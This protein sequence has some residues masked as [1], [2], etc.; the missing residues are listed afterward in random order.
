MPPTGDIAKLFGFIAKETP[1]STHVFNAAIGAGAKGVYNLATGR[2]LTDGMVGAGIMGAAA[3]AGW[4]TYKGMGLAG[5]VAKAE[6]GYTGAMARVANRG[7]RAAAAVEAGGFR[8]EL[9]TY[10][11]QLGLPK[12]GLTSNRAAQ[13]GGVVADAAASAERHVT[14][15][16]SSPGSGPIGQSIKQLRTYDTSLGSSIT[17]GRAAASGGTKQIPLRQYDMAPG[18]KMTQARASQSRAFHYQDASSREASRL[19]GQTSQAQASWT[20][21]NQRVA[22][23][24]VG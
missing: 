12:R 18:A 1:K 7:E 9:N 24:W 21:M 3:G 17:K 6:A 4:K 2:D 16:A 19:R 15:S 20:N 22:G 23:A 14:T 13:R 11:K 5:K 10:R 8:T